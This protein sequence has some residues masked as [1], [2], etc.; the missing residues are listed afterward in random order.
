MEDK[1]EKRRKEGQEMSATGNLV[2]RWQSADHEERRHLEKTYPWFFK[3]AK[4]NP[5]PNFQV[6][7]KVTNQRF[8]N[9]HGTVV[10]LKDYTSRCGWRYEVEM[11]LN[12]GGTKITNWLEDDMVSGWR[13]PVWES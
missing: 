2:Q 11:I 9:W 1:P 6:G 8:G 13:K 12:V 10:G 4:T 5:E 3:N 7:Q